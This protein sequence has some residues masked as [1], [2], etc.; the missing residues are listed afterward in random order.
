LA[1][2]RV[3]LES[4]SEPILIS[5]TSD[6]I[7]RAL[8]EYHTDS[9]GHLSFERFQYIK[10]KHCE[11]SG[12][13][14]GESDCSRGWFPSNRV[15]RV[16][17]EYEAEVRKKQIAKNN[18]NNNNGATKLGCGCVIFDP[19]SF[20]NSADPKSVTNATNARAKCEKE[21]H[22]LTLLFSLSPPFLFFSSCICWTLHCLHTH[23]L[24]SLFVFSLL[25]I[26]I[27]PAQRL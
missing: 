12:W 4:S 24:S 1:T 25:P 7:V 5:A 19:L 20:V 22:L 15:E 13:W 16:A 2:G 10:V 27:Y 17:E 14:L 6:F 3:S 26:S 9:E 18:N 21:A 8:H 23:L 11:P